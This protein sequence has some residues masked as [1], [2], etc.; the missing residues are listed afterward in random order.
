[1]FLPAVPHRSTLSVC[2]KGLVLYWDSLVVKRKQ[3]SKKRERE[4]LNI[5]VSFSHIQVKRNP[6]TALK[7]R[8]KN[9]FFH[10]NKNSPVSADVCWIWI[11]FLP[12]NGTGISLCFSFLITTTICSLPSSPLFFFCFLFLAVCFCFSSCHERQEQ[13]RVDWLQ[14]GY[15]L[16][17]TENRRVK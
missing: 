4:K 10:Q 15:Y 12:V 16:P 13:C 11:M 6:I 8:T 14:A 17:S 9:L 5:A 2:S 7:A 1:M 3:R